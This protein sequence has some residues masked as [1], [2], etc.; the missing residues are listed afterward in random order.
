MTNLYNYNNVDHLEQ[1][2]FMEVAG[3]LMMGVRVRRRK[4]MED[5]LIKVEGVFI[6]EAE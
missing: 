4:A 5:V 2:R 1:T 6:N 3:D